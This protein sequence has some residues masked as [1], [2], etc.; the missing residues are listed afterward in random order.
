EKAYLHSDLVILCYV[1]FVFLG[2]STNVKSIRIP[3]IKN[4]SI[5]NTSNWVFFILF[6]VPMVPMFLSFSFSIAGIRS[7]YETVVFSRY[8]SF[9][10]LS[11]LFLYVILI[12]RM[13]KL[14][15]LS[16]SIWIWTPFFF[17]FGSKF[18]VFDFFILMLLFLEYFK[19]ISLVKFFGIASLVA[20]LLIFYRYAQTPSGD[21]NI[22]L[23]ALG[24]FDQYKNQSFVIEKILS[25]EKDYYFGWI[26]LSSYLKYIPRFLWEAK[27]Y[28]FGFAILNWHFMPKEAAAGYMPAF[29]LGGLFSDFGYYGVAFFGYSAGFIKRLLYNA[30]QK[31]R[32]NLSFILFALPFTFVSL[33]IVVFNLFL[34][35]LLINVGRQK[36]QD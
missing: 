9:F 20:L 11:K 27:P 22:W 28:D 25:G 14:N 8:A 29:G 16:W 19:D 7:F 23:N 34:N 24:Y 18:V 2:V 1:V 17:L 26:Y 36:T 6:L 13:V 33:I 30:F 10:E 15:R 31:S 35:K 12:Y 21:K 32:N 4:V 5:V 3:E